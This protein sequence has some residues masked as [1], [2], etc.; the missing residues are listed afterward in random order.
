[1][2]ELKLYK[3]LEESP[4]RFSRPSFKQG[5]VSC[6]SNILHKDCRNPALS[7]LFKKKFTHTLYALGL[8]RHPA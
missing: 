2:G 5:D 1:M 8:N 7:R 6:G 3:A 4:S